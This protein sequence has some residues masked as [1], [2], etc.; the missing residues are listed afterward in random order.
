MSAQ[1]FPS[2]DPLDIRIMGEL[3][4][5]ARQTY[6]D[7]AVKLGVSRPTT[8]GRIGRLL[9]SGIL[10]IICWADPVALGYKFLVTLSIYTHPGRVNDVAA[11]LAAYPQV[12]HVHLCTGRFNIIAWAMFRDG[13]NLS[14]FLSN[15]LGSISEVLNV[16][17]MLTLQQVKLFPWLL[18]DEKEP[19]NPEKRAKDLD[20][21]DLK[22]I[23]ELQKDVRQKAGHLARK[24]GVNRTTIIRRTQR[25]TDEHVIRIRTAVHPF[26]LGYE[27]IAIIG[28]KCNPD[29]VREI[30]DAVASY[31]NVQYVGICAGRYDITAWVEFRKLHDLRHFITVELGSIAGLKDTD[32][33]IVY[34]LVKTLDQLPL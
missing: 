14:N 28:L 24:L 21:L 23:G 8:T 16:D 9:D 4:A 31:S 3:E 7:L 6:K 11:R 20:D 10:R 17:T 12:S 13:E 18:T 2:L 22:L 5:D 27:G 1:S 26:A 33:M 19:Y 25:L 32:T 15:D 29:K 34:K 30:A